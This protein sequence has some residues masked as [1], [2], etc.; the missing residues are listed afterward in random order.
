MSVVLP[1]FPPGAQPR[2]LPTSHGPLAAVTLGAAR[3]GQAL[4]VP[5]F[6]GS[7]EDFT[8]L[9]GPLADAGYAVT[10]LDLRGQ[11]ES[12][13]SDDP[14]RYTVDALGQDVREAL[15]HLRPEVDGPLHLVGHSFGGLVC[16]AALLAEPQAADSLVLLGSGP[17]ALT[18]PRVEALQLVRPLVEQGRMQEVADL[19][20]AT[21]EMDPRRAGTPQEVR[22]FLRRRF[23]A[24]CPTGLLTTADALTSEP[25]RVVALAATGVPV[26]VVLGEHDDAWPP[27]VQRE[28]A[29]RLGTVA[30]E[31]AGAFHSPAAEA[32]EATAAVLV[33]FWGA[34]G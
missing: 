27:D 30:V 28:M 11:H 24:S 18:G 14:A 15:E 16:R 33:A 6:T 3:R 22:D 4:L 21:L 2:R 29:R 32:P 25:D 10:A 5:G 9:V 19:M 34:L 31:V 23:L 13:R 8:A 12:A 26:A 17:S 20:D 7:K 1:V